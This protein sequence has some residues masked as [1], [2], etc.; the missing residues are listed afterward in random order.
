MTMVD[1]YP[2]IRPLLMALPPEAAHGVTLRLLAA[3]WVPGAS[4]DAG[5]SLRTRLWDRDFPNP[6]GLA[7]GFD[8]HAEA[9]DALA[10]LG[11]G[12]VELGGVTPLPQPGNPRPR[13][14]R[15]AEDKAVINRMGFNS[16]GFDVVAERLT[17]RRGGGIVGINLGRNKDSKTEAAYDYALGVTRFGPLVDFLAL[18]VSS[19]NTPGLRDLQERSRLED[20]LRH[21]LAAR[22]ALAGK[23]PALLVKIAPDLDEEALAG[24]ADIAVNLRLDGLIV[25]NTT[26]SRPAGL[27]SSHKDEAGG[28]SGAPLFDLATRVLARMYVLTDGRIPLIGVGGIESGADAYAKIRAGASLIQLYSALIYHGPALIPRILADLAA[29]LSRDGFTRIAD[30]VGTGTRR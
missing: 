13:L 26:L 19:P 9:A 12:F 22:D 10:G 29:M 5:P 7:A 27:R 16:D 18:N 24:V 30:A 23:R 21:A 1:L 8:K 3:G 17:R 14:F 4:A 15:L 6:L 20:V 28:L 11:F 2:L 25:S